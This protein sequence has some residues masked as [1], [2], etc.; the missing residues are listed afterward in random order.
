MTR[1]HL[2]GALLAFGS[3][4]ILPACSVTATRASNPA[5]VYS[6]NPELSPGMVRQ[7]QTALQ[8]QG[9]YNG[10]IDGIWGP[11]TQSAV[12]SFQQS[13]ALSPTGTLNSPTLAALNMPNNGAAAPM[14]PAAAMQ[15]AAPAPTD[16]TSMATPAPAMAPAPIDTTSSP[17]P[18][19]PPMPAVAATTSTTVVTPTP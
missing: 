6:S 12:Q 17:T 19:A 11:Q 4:A 18:I 10:S 16:T 7:V 3:L 9:L 13:H 8:Q 2:A 1:F 15:P 5:P 14:P